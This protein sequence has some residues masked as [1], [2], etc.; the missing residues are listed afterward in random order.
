MAEEEPV[1]YEGWQTL[2]DDEQIRARVTEGR[3]LI[4]GV[5]RTD[6]PSKCALQPLDIPPGTSLETPHLWPSEVVV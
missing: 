5:K 1:M 2:F 6:D 3:C 4:C